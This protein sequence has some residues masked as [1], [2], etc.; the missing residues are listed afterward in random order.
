[1]NN[2]YKIKLTTKEDVTILAD[3]YHFERNRSEYTFFLDGA[4]I[5]V[6]DKDYVIGVL[7]VELI[8]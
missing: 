7:S 2:G 5:A 8:C 4:T 6:F 1:M 3:S